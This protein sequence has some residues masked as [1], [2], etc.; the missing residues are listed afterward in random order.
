MNTATIPANIKIG[1][2]TINELP[3]LLKKCGSKVLLVHGH[4]PVE[5]G[6]LSKVRTILN[7]ANFP[8]ANLGQILPN[9]KYDSVKRG[10]K[11]ARKENCD[12]I[13]SLG[14]GSTLQC[15][16]AIALGMG[17]KGDVWDFW[18]GKKKAKKVYPIASILT[19][20]SSGTE[21]SSGCTIVK[22]GKQ[23]T[24]HD[25]KLK[26]TFTILD[27]N[28]AMYPIYPTVNQIFSIFEHLFFAYLEKDAATQQRAVELLKELLE[29]SKKLEAND[30]D[31][32]ARTELFRIGLLTHLEIGSVKIGFEKLANN[33]S[34]QFSLPEGSAGS[35]L[36]VAWCKE[37]DEENKM[38]ICKLG[39][40]LFGL[41]K[42]DFNKTL[43]EFAKYFDG[44]NLPLSIKETGLQISNKTLLKAAKTK[45][46]KKILK[47]ANY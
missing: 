10:I 42:N 25:P 38:K 17:Y 34:F 11:V 22:K 21:I 23:K 16:K 45:E 44:M 39:Q 15:A 33:V 26:C 41:E 35:A 18:T 29:C 30:H 5:D 13:L 19:N 3:D 24:V 37:L 8:H 9:P 28:V 7:K 43:Q 31:V 46:D 4:R 20:P 40:D 36:F 12:I 27:P 2:D 1:P 47:N 14:G 6:L 32:E